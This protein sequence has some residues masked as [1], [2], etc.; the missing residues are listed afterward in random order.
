MSYLKR[1]CPFTLSKF[2]LIHRFVLF[3]VYPN[4]RK[5][6]MKNGTGRIIPACAA[7][8]IEP[9]TGSDQ[10]SPYTSANIPKKSVS[11][12]MVLVFAL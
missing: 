9:F 11:K 12:S 4:E 7:L 1:A 10:F 2:V 3:A 6:S 5:K 8:F